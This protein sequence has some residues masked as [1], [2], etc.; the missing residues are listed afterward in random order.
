MWTFAHYWGNYSI[1]PTRNCDG[2]RCLGRKFVHSRGTTDR[3]RSRS[4][5]ETAVEY[6]TRFAFINAVPRRHDSVL[7]AVAKNDA[8]LNRNR[9]GM[10]VLQHEPRSRAVPWEGSPA[11][12]SPRSVW[13]RHFSVEPYTERAG[14]DGTALV[15]LSKDDS[16]RS[17]ARRFFYFKSPGHGKFRQAAVA[18]YARAGPVVRSSWSWDGC[19]LCDCARQAGCHQQFKSFELSAP[20]RGPPSGRTLVCSF[21]S[22]GSAG[23]AFTSFRAG[24][25]H[26]RVLAG[27][28]L[29]H[30]IF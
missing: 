12:L 11:G 18:S 21:L 8:E 3:S 27:K 9:P 28:S 23:P 29:G 6:P 19:R 1:R 13:T 17:A 4:F 16:R 22:R 20:A 24:T 26:G 15:N 25:P 14:L 30:L 2:V 10:S 7:L 5:S